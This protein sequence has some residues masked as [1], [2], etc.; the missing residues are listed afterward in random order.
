NPLPRNGTFGENHEQGGFVFV[1]KDPYA[2]LDLSRA[3]A[4]L[5]AWTQAKEDNT[6]VSYERYLRQHPQGD[7]ITLAQ[8]N[9]RDINRLAE[10]RR[11]QAAWQ[12]AQNNPS[13]AIYTAFIDRFP[14]SRHLSEAREEIKHLEAQAARAADEAAWQ[15]AQDCNTLDC[16]W[17]YL[18]QQKEGRYQNEAQDRMKILRREAQLAREVTAWQAAKTEDTPGAYQR[19]LDQYPSG[20][21]AELARTRIQSTPDLPLNL[22]DYGLPTYKL[23]TIEGGSFQMGSDEGDRDEKPIHMVS[24]SS[25]QLGKTEV[26]QALWQAVMGENPSYV[27]G[28]NLPVKSASW[29]DCQQFIQKLNRKTGLNF[30]LPTEAEWEYAAGGGATGRTTYAGT[31][32]SKELANYGNFCDQRCEYVGDENQSDGYVNTAPVASFQANRLGLYDMSGNVFEWCQDWYS[33]DYYANSPERNPLGPSS[34]TS[35]VLRGGSW[36]GYTSILRVA[37]RVHDAPDYRYFNGGFR[38]SRTP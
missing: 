16:Y 18:D 23:L 19:F 27:K 2:N 28:D 17:T 3:Q 12:Q 25:F 1:R 31:N 30:R 33:S 37:V 32:D 26:T 29:E 24:V 34:G 5:S 7:F 13:V 6:V 35:R 8:Q 38:L 10:Q 22:A 36:V 4:D 9:I 15:R 11:E 21:Y 14:R 20:A